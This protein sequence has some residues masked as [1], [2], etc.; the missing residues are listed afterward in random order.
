MKED[1]I[2][3]KI[4]NLKSYRPSIRVNRLFSELVNAV[5]SNNVNVDLVD[6]HLLVKINEAC[7]RAE[8]E[9]EKYWSNRIFR[10]TQ[11]I[12]EIEEFPY[13]RNYR[14]LANLEYAL[15]NSCTSH[16]RKHNL[17]FVGGGPL[18]MT[19]IILYKLKKINSTIIEYDA[20]A[21][22]KS[23]QL[24]KKMG[25]DKKISVVEVDALKFDQY[26]KF[27]LIY[28]AALVGKDDESK[29]K[30][31]NNIRNQIGSDVHVLLRGSWGNRRLLYNNLSLE[32]IKNAGFKIITETHPH[33]DIINS[34]YLIKKNDKNT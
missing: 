11:P 4:L 30:I 5:Q 9:L 13:Y 12:I 6:Q 27:N 33:N 10:S 1:K 26:A 16:G 23:R 21:V 3:N 7:S 20:I 14:D 8:F 15:F 31:L 17:L 25:L 24:L 22:K 18:P 28:F 19:S 29:V 34:I 32:A 2:I